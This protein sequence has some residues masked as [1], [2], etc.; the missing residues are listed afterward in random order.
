MAGLLSGLTTR[1]RCLVAA[2]AAA[3]LC[4]I[5]LDERDLLRVAVF[6]VALPVLAML[7]T[8]RA[9]IGLAARRRLDPPRLP[10]GEATTVRVLVTASGRLPAGGLMAED[11]VPYQF[12]EP[13]RFAVRRL[14][15]PTPTPGYGA[16]A[17]GGWA[18]QRGAV[19]LVYPLRPAARGVHRIGPLTVRVSD[20]FGLAEYGREL[21]G[22]ERLVVV[23]AT[24][25]LAGL[26]AVAGLGTG[27]QGAGRL[28]LGQGDDDVV[29]R[30]YQQGDD[31]RKVHWRS[32]ARHDELMVRVE[33]RP[34]Q[35]GTTV[36][37]DRRVSAH[38]GQGPSASLEWAISFAASVCLHLMR[39]GQRVRLVTTDG[40]TLTGGSAGVEHGPDAVLD[41]LAALTPSHRR[42]VVRPPG[43]RD[44]KHLIAVFG[45]IGPGTAE[46][47]ATMRRRGAHGM[48]VLLDTANWTG[49]EGTGLGA[50]V[51]RA[52]DGRSAQDAAARVLSAAGWAVEPAGPGDPIGTV[53]RRLCVASGTATDQ[54]WDASDDSGARPGDGSAGRSEPS[55]EPPVPAT[56][57]AIGADG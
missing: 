49:A 4:A 47:V 36:L 55:R 51:E 19:E 14:H 2:G 37:L 8:G 9:R 26:P 1:G 39:Q 20:P 12:G 6:A 52:P 18:T 57:A 44:G 15:R 21:G 42:E 46:Q 3:A 35:G 5:V 16:S 23:P 34:W 7:V 40:A 10:V 24:T 41:A 22:T 25:A 29:V 11:R 13:P 27:E 17:P 48:A 56:G 54:H 33:E 45:A 38:H 50:P 28:R 31:L 32:T 53:W 43:V 30:P